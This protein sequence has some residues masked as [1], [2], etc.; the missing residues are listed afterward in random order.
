MHASIRDGFSEVILVEGLFDFVSLWQAGFRNVTCSLST[1]LNSLQLR[2]LCE[3][4]DRVVYLAFDSDDNGSGQAAA[5]HLSDY[6]AQQ[7]VPAKIVA[8]PPNQ[9]PNTFFVG[10][11]TACQFRHLLEQARP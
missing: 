10:G 3:Q 5:R 2:Q 8:L 6:L 1:H 4:T 11:G 9:D 7:K